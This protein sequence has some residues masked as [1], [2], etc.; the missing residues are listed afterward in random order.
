MSPEDQFTMAHNVLN[1][2]DLLLVE[3][4]FSQDS[5]ARHHLKIAKSMFRQAEKEALLKDKVTV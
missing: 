1:R 4:G 5:S 2:L 3:A